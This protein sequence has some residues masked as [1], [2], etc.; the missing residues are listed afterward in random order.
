MKIIKGL[1]LAGAVAAATLLAGCSFGSTTYAHYANADKYVAGN[2]EITEKI[3]RIDI[4]YISG[5]IK[6]LTEDTDKVTITETAKIELDADRQVHTW[7]EG[8]TLHVRYC[9]A[10]KRLDL[11]NL[12]KRLEI[13]IPG[14]VIYSDVNINL[15]SGD[16]ETGNIKA[17][18]INL[19]STSGDRV[20]NC[21]AETI[22]IN[23]TSGNLDLTQSG[24]SDD[25]SIDA[26][27]G[28]L[29]IKLDEAKNLIVNSTS[30]T[31]KVEAESVEKIDADSSSGS[32][33]FILANVP[34]STTVNATSGDVTFSL[35]SD[36]GFSAVINTTSGDVRSNIPFTSN[37]ETYIFGNGTGS[38]D[39]DTTSGDVIFNALD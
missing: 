38:M 13:I 30:G 25:I 37:G 10:D 28:S 18:S 34:E 5:D 24:K 3:D 19:D 36:A 8:S 1:F 32:K 12:D 39:I 27:S 9:A 29:N 22:T 16:L 31:L 11:N 21:E 7:V 26:T 17:E 2:Q 35:P 20:V 4:D 6:L 14:D 23:A 15:T 33:T